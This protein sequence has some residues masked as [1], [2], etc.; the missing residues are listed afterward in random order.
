MSIFDN[1][2]DVLDRVEVGRRRGRGRR[3]YFNVGA[4]K[5]ADENLF[6]LWYVLNSQCLIGVAV[7]VSLR[8]ITL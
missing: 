3:G 5:R 6:K 7:I 2:P 1:S 4:R 8:A